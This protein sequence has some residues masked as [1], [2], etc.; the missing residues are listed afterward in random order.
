MSS[1][2]LF[3][4]FSLCLAKKNFENIKKKEKRKEKELNN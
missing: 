1:F 3:S 2:F 4:F